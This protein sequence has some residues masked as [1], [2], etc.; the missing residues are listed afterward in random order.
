MSALRPTTA[1]PSNN[2]LSTQISTYLTSK[3]LPPTQTWL[4]SFL[5]TIRGSTPLP[6]LQKTALFR[7]LASDLTASITTTP[8]TTLPP[9]IADPVVKELRLPGLITVQVLDVE[10]VGKSRW[11]QLESW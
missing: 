1:A 2:T 11:S 3:N 5:P 4:S 8:A 6:A 9:N 7:I 10:D